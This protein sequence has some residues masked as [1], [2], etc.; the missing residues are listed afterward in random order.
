MEPGYLARVELTNRSELTERFEQIIHMLEQVNK[1]ESLFR[2]IRN[3][4]KQ[5][6]EVHVSTTSGVRGDELFLIILNAGVVISTI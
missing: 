4:Q 6:H 1:Q 5:W 2:H 3:D